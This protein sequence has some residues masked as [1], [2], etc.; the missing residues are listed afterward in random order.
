MPPNL[1]DT[2]KIHKGT[3]TASSK[4]VLHN[5]TF[6]LCI[7]TNWRKFIFNRLLNSITEPIM[8]SNGYT[9]TWALEF[10][11]PMRILHFKSIPN[12]NSYLGA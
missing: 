3:W 12:I 5:S 11:D 9:I 10:L 4:P 1:N 7:K 8:Q 2:H 6:K